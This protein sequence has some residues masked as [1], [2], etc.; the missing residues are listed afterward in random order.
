MTVQ[1]D[2]TAENNALRL[3]NQGAAPATPSVNHT[4]LYIVTGTNAGLYIKNDVGQQIGP[5]I[6]GSATGGRVLIAEVL[7][8]GTT[9]T[10]ASSIAGTYKKLTLEFAVRSTNASADVD[11][12]LQFNNDTT[13]G[14]YNYINYRSNSFGVSN[15]FAASYTFARQSIPGASATANYFCV[16]KIDIIQYANTT[17]YKTANIQYM[18]YDNAFQ[19]QASGGLNWANTNAINRIDMALSAGN[20]VA[21]SVIRLYGDT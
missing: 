6:T 11:G 13:A 7:P 2:T 18:T 19:Q 8:T 1:I 3:V 15:D 20:F 10:I 21:G 5:F 14:N 4:L 12:Y 9:I 16:G 17:F